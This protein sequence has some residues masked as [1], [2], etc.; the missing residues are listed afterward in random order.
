MFVSAY[1]RRLAALAA[2][3]CVAG[4]AG[5]QSAG[6]PLTPGNAAPALAPLSHESAQQRGSRPN[7]SKSWMKPGMVSQKLLYVSDLFGGVVNVYTY[8]GLTYAGQ[9][10]GFTFPTGECTDRA[11]NVW[12]TD[13]AGS[14]YEYAHGGTTALSTLTSS[15]NTPEGCA[16]DLKTGALAISNGNDQVLVFHN[17]TGT[18]TVYSDA[19][20]SRTTFLGYDNQ[21]NLFVD[22]ADNS[23]LFHFA[24]LPAGSS[25]FTDIALSATPSVAGNVQWDGKYVAVGDQ[26]STIY[27]TQ[28]S[29]VIG[30]TTLSSTCLGQFYIVTSKKKVIAPDSC[31]VD[32]DTYAYP[33]GGA[34]IKTV[35]GGLTHPSGVVL[36]L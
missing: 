2:I 3:A 11:G 7:H 21:G 13:Q 17:A 19:N 20:F 12:I 30:T 27:R 8:P 24:E 34:A 29:N 26:G 22:G 14:V 10:T 36:S 16:I 5:Q 4:C 32:V 15:V 23:L 28:G 31:N 33:A 18:P 25:G 35:T 6:S 9:L 1:W